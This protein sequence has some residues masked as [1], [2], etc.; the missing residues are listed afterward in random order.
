MC[1]CVFMIC[2]MRRVDSVC[3]LSSCSVYFSVAQQF[4]AGEYFPPALVIFLMAGSTCEP[5]L[6]S[7]SYLD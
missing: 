4:M 3:V 6:L 2:S 7:V 1:V 5:L